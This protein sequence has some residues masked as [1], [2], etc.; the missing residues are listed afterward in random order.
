MA[1][2]KR[3]AADI[4]VVPYIDVML[5]LL[6]IFMVTAPLL[7]QGVKVDLPQANSNPLEQKKED[8]L[9]VSM[10]ADGSLSVNLGADKEQVRPLSE[11]QAMVMKV[12]AEKPETAVLVWS[13]KTVQ[14]GEV[15][16]LMAKL[17]EAG[18]QQVGLVT[19]A[20]GS[21]TAS[22]KERSR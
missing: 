6:V 2:K 8:P 19:E 11:V 20:L 13:D 16:T 3:L 15:V 21:N 10:R 4:N 22:K 17:Q 18:V 12:L 7:T 9:I 14:Y 1:S 5:V